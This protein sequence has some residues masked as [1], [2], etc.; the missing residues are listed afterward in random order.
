LNF[1]VFPLSFFFI[2]LS[3]SDCGGL[4]IGDHLV[5]LLDII[6]LLLRDFNCFL[7][8]V[9]F[10][11]AFSLSISFRGMFFFF[12][13][14]NLSICYRLALASASLYSFSYSASFFSSYYYCLVGFR[15]MFYEDRTKCYFH[16][17]NFTHG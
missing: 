8:N 16:S 1:V 2:K 4:S 11:S 15:I 10:C 5:H 9:F 17:L 3:F 7:I 13:Y 12:S 14:S 6:E